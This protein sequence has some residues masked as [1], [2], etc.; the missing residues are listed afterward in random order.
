MAAKLRH[1]PANMAELHEQLG[2]IPL[3]RIQL[4]SSPGLATEDDV[5][6]IAVSKTRP[7]CELLD[8]TLVEK[9]YHNW[10]SIQTA[11]F[12]SQLLGFI[13]KDD[14]GIVVGPTCAFRMKSG[15]VIFPDIS[16][17]PWDTFPDGEI[18]NEEISAIPPE[19]A[20]KILLPENTVQETD[21][22]VRELFES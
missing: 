2:W 6:R 15:S 7:V 1:K 22:F 13:Q 19:L 20:V 14:L 3:A 4:D 5:I 9:A 12:S 18:P 8:G 16:F 10:K 11:Q 21:R 17:I